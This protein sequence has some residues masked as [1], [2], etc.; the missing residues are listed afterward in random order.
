MTEN[1]VVFPAPLGPISAVMRPAST[2]SDTSSRAIKPPK[3]LDTRS[4][5]SNGSA[6]GAPR[7][8]RSQTHHVQTQIAQEPGNSVGREGHDHDQHAAVNREVEARRV[9][10]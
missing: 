2:A 9:A 4:T 3:P 7:R 5:R 1:S 8:R 6:M 10:H